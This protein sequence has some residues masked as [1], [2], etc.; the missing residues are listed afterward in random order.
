VAN[1]PFQ[2][3]KAPLKPQKPEVPPD[4]R[5]AGGWLL[6]V[7]TAAIL[8]GVW[9][10]A[11][12]PTLLDIAE[13]WTSDATYSYGFVVPLFSLFLLWRRRTELR[14]SKFSPSLW[15]FCFLLLGVLL[16][17]AGARFYFDWLGEVSL[18]PS[19]IGLCVGVW[20]WPALH[21]AWPA[22]AFLGFMLPLPHRMEMSVALP[23]QRMATTASTY[24]LQTVGVAAVAEGNVILLEESKKI[25]VVE[26]CNGLGM[27]MTLF[28]L[29]AGV[30]LVVRRPWL[31]K[32]IM[33][34]SAVPV[35]FL[36]NVARIT[37]T[38]LLLNFAGEE[39]AGFFHSDVVASLFMMAFALAML[40]LELWI[41]SR[42]L[43]EPPA[44]TQPTF[45][46]STRKPAQAKTRSAGVK[47][48]TSAS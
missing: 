27:L 44:K 39:V 15:G 17:L 7:L 28:A 42:V 1:N 12:W 13:R 11:Y 26:A 38:G 19:L 4:P 5:P 23:L 22:I 34:A 35:A 29:T 46:L 9:F 6:L 8:G 3:K 21:W 37:I 41:L 32:I 14:A 33:V 20:G 47:P 43:V 30:A 48:E 40:W 16:H 25:E 45:G 31:D 10:W 24:V 2:K 18:V 36:S